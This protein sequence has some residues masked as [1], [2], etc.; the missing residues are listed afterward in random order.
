MTRA[1]QSE[2]CLGFSASSPGKGGLPSLPG[3]NPKGRQ[4][5]LRGGG[6]DGAAPGRGGR[7]GGERERWREEDKTQRDRV[8]PAQF[9]NSLPNLR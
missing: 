6:T 7:R 5:E 9:F 3:W 4:T 1:G 8:R 2:P